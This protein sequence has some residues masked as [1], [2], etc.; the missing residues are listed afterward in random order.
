MKLSLLTLHDTKVNK[1]A[2]RRL[3]FRDENGYKI[4][5]REHTEQCVSVGERI[6]GPQ[7]SI[8]LTQRKGVVILPGVVEGTR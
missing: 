6:V 8:R 4:T 2:A 7:Q 3:R 5:G 1:H